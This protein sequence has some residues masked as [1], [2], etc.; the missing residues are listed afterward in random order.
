MSVPPPTAIA[1]HD[2]T[3]VQRLATRVKVTVTGQVPERAS[4]SVML[5]RYRAAGDLY[6]QIEEGASRVSML[7][8]ESVHK[9]M[10]EVLPGR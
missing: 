7:A 10:I 1:Y 6:I 4:G 2:L 3:Y 9:A 5:W 8:G